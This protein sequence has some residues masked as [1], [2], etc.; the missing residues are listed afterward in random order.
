M[1]DAIAYYDEADPAMR[2]AAAPR[3]LETALSRPPVKPMLAFVASPVWD[4]ADED[5]K[6][7]FAELVSAL[8]DGIDEIQLPQPFE[9]AHEF[10]RTIMFADIAKN[11]QRYHEMDKAQLSETLR[12]MIE[13]GQR[14]LAVDYARAHDWIDVLNLALDEIFKRYDALVT[15]AATGEAPLG[16][17]STGNPVFSTIWTYCGVPV[18]TVPL[19]TGASGMPIGAQLVCRRG[20]DARLLRTA[21][22]LVETLRAEAGEGRAVA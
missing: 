14:I 9:R 5:M 1:A 20:H 11:F 10:H 2:L 16:L 13:E 6:E 3:L 18:V 19:L 21:R 12:G 17:D 22:W 7:G 8:G 15:P 4:K